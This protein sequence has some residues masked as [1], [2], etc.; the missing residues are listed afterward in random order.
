MKD[1]RTITEIF[2]SRRKPVDGFPTL[3][4]KQALT[5]PARRNKGTG[6]LSAMLCKAVIVAL[7]GDVVEI[8]VLEPPGRMRVKSRSQTHR[9]AL[10]SASWT[11][12]AMWLV[13]GTVTYHVGLLLIAEALMKQHQ[14][15][16]LLD[17]WHELLTYRE[18]NKPKDDD[19]RYVELVG[20]VSDELWYWAA[21]EDKDPRTLNRLTDLKI[22]DATE[23]KIVTVASKI[24]PD[25]LTD[26]RALARFRSKG[27]MPVSDQDP[28]V[29]NADSQFRGWQL[30]E[31]VEDLKLGFHCLLVGPTATGKSLSAMDAFRLADSQRS[32]F[33]IEGHESMKEFDL[34][35]GYIPDGKNKFTW[36]DGALVAA[37]RAGGFLFI[38]EANRMPTRTL[39]VLLGILSRSAVVLTEHGSEQVNAQKGFQ[40]IMAM[41]LGRGYAVNILD[42]ALLNRFAVTLE[43]RYLPFREEVELLVSLTGIEQTTAEVMV[44]VAE[45]TRAKKKNHEL[46]GEITPRG[47]VAWA[48]KIR[49]KSEDM[50]A[51]LKQAAKVTWMHAV[52]GVDTDGYLRDDIAA[53]LYVLIESHVP[54]GAP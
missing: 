46:S 29:I 16:D 54:R 2:F 18:R 49:N 7:K 21:Y 53:E 6:Y 19:P 32:V 20:H 9:S 40:V 11:D 38:D 41:N 36:H 12:E 26:A 5:Y 30:P 28:V 3:S 37:M 13:Y 45:E 23:L 44:K 43:Y 8:A 14:A 4:G 31:L 50:V 24:D 25:V 1:T 51:R 15:T 39:N 17:A 10:T 27:A 48:E 47:L 34:L 33:V 35:G 52:A 42:D 22:N